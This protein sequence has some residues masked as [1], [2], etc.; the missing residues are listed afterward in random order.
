MTIL[1]ISTRH[2]LRVLVVAAVVKTANVR[3]EAGP[4]DLPVICP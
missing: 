3:G 1:R 2:P 4:C